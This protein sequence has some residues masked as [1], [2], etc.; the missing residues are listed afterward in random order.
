MILF[1]LVFL[2]LYGGLNVYVYH[3]IATGLG[4]HSWSVAA[5][6]GFLVLSPFLL[7]FFERRKK[8]L[9]ATLLAWL[10]FHWMGIAFLFACFALLYDVGQLAFPGISDAEALVGTVGL[11]VMAVAYGFYESRQVEVHF[12]SVQSPKLEDESFRVVQISDLHLGYGT[13]PGHIRKILD[14]VRSLEPDLVVSTGDL[15]D[16]NLE[17]LEGYA[18]LL[19]SLHPPKGKIAVTGNHEVYAGLPQALDLT[20][21]SGFRVLRSASEEVAP[22]LYVAGVDDP[23]AL[24]GESTKVAEAEALREVPEGAVA[25]LLKHRPDITANLVDKFDLQ[26][27]GHTHGGQIFPFVFLTRLQYRAKLGLSQVASEAFLY[28][29]RGTGTW[30]P[31]IR[32]FAPPEIAVFDFLPGA[33]FSISRV[34][35]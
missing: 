9:V 17:N 5:A 13:V 19:K 25:I 15:F 12:L 28:L 31:Q 29:S 14:Q 10:A 11:T 4:H 6:L 3:T 16:G 1:L 34:K 23:E 35:R 22:N 26:L 7:R 18:Q 30:G 2:T 8:T 21:R 32:V 20:E 33:D 24:E 27:S